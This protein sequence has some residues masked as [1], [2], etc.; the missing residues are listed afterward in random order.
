[1]L[2]MHQLG[3]VIAQALARDAAGTVPRDLGDA[4]ASHPE[5]AAEA[6]KLL[7]AESRKK[8]ANSQLTL[9]FSI[10]LE[11]AL[12]A[13]RWREENG[14]ASANNLIAAVRATVLNEA[15]GHKE[16]MRAL[17]AISRCFSA[18]KV[19]PGPDL[20]R[21]LKVCVVSEPSMGQGDALRNFE[22]SFHRLAEDLDHD[23]FLIHDQLKDLIS[24]VPAEPRM[25]LIAELAA[26]PILSLREAIVGF[27]LDPDASVGN[28]TASI[29]K[30]CASEG[31]VSAPTVGRMVILRNWLGEDRR[32]VIDAAIRAARRKGISAA[33][34][35]AV[36]IK[37]ILV[38]ACD[39]AGAQSWFVIL[40]DRL[41]FAIAALLIK[42]GFGLRDA[43]VR[44]GLTGTEA[45]A[46]L[47]Q[48]EI[49]MC[50]FESSLECVG[51]ALEHGLA[52]ALEKGEAI[53]FRLIQ[54]I[55]ATGVT[56]FNPAQHSPDALLNQL[57]A[58]LPQGCRD[59]TAISRALAR[60]KR[61]QKSLE[62]AD[63]WFEDSEEA[64]HVVEQG[65]TKKDKIV[66]VLRDVVADR[67]RYWG[68]LLAW[69]VFGASDDEAIGEAKD[70]ALV[71]RELLSSRPLAD[72]P[73]AVL[74]AKNTVEAMQGRRRR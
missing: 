16:D 52:V 28:A 1:M 71:A 58:D 6:V 50:N 54:F 46:F 59:D 63:L 33:P 40:R 65:P 22:A 38:S 73:F 69:T 19:D 15:K 41:K 39:G 14:S 74:I 35:L 12:E 10:M 21:A 27:L 24:A 60:S 20:S 42:H 8:R 51:T 34:R 26:S 53:P 64:L 45:K 55:E 48:L 2:P 17:L 57:I 62:W 37:E 36:Q 68:E 43:W 3:M 67:R 9:A 70:F 11:K 4:L 29:L 32:S 56:S 44:T 47:A 13:A 31:L 66:N 18:A 5:S 72:I 30:Q 49:E 23:C 61:W 25:A 7:F